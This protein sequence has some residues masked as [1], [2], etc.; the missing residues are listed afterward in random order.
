MEPI[1]QNFGTNVDYKLFCQVNSRYFPVFCIFC[2][3]QEKYTI[4]SVTSRSGVTFAVTTDYLSI[5]L[6]VCLSIDR[7][8]YL[9]IYGY[10]N[11]PREDFMQVD[12]ASK[13][14]SIKDKKNSAEREGL[15]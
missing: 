1:G 12:C 6:S 14:I 15:C 8:V 13:H 5:Y 7:S 11:T 4:P 2:F 9:S 10:F 3:I